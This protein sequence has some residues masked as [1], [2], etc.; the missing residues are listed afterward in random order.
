MSSQTYITVFPMKYQKKKYNK[1]PKHFYLVSHTI[2]SFIFKYKVLK[3]LSIHFGNFLSILSSY[4]LPIV[5]DEI[6]FLHFFVFLY[7]CLDQLLKYCDILL[8]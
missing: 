2:I 6:I 8:V 4:S 1:K 5:S 3:L 7:F